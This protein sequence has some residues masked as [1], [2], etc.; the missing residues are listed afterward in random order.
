MQSRA[1]RTVQSPSWRTT[2]PQ[3]TPGHAAQGERLKRPSLHYATGAFE[4]QL[5]RGHAQRQL[6]G[7]RPA[8]AAADRV[9]LRAGRVAPSQPAEPVRPAF[10]DIGHGAQG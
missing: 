2:P 9:E 1:N 6:V 4:D 7:A 5:S 3:Q 8:N 10:H